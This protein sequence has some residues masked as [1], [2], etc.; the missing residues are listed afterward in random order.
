M[1]HYLCN[2]ASKIGQFRIEPIHRTKSTQGISHV[3]VGG[4]VMGAQGD[5]PHLASR[6]HIGKAVTNIAHTKVELWFS[7]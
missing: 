7:S 3:P 2:A 5:L 6:V 4:D 1:C